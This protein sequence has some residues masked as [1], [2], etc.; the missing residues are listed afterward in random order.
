MEEEKEEE[1]S[2]QMLRWCRERREVGKMGWVRIVEVWTGNRRLRFREV[3]VGG[4]GDVIDC[5]CTHG[6]SN[7]QMIR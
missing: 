6:T 2:E 3:R 7:H 4:V 1:R 5:L